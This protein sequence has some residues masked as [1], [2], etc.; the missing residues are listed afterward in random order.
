MVDPTDAARVALVTGANRG[1]GLETA[2]GLA[3]A[4]FRVALAVR[5]VA[6]GE[7]ARAD[8]LQ[9]VPD[10]RLDVHRLDLADL[11][12]VARFAASFRD[13]SPRLDVLVNNAGFHVADRIVTPDR[14]ESTFAASHLGHFLLTRE[15]LPLLQRSAPSRVVTVASE[16]HRGGRIRFD[17]LMGERSWNGIRAYN[18]AKLANVAFA[19]ELARR[20]EGTGV[21]SHALHPGVVRTGWAR[22][23]ESGIFRFAAALASPFMLSAEKG[24]R[25]SLHV[26]LSEEAGALNGRYW[27]RSRP[28]P[29][30]R[31]ARDRETGR[32]LWEVSARLVD[33]ALAR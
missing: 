10:A 27:W 13:S 33:A 31:E 24:A 2:R 15:L 8:I 18:Q 25:T 16:A 12:D 22:G 32:R 17:D 20:V 28:I 26:A 29:P 21:V 14:Y 9:S 5:D 11:K 4:G 30:S 6:R 19:L 7:A 3:R 23:E 1:I